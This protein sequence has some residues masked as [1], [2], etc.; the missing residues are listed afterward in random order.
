MNRLGYLGML[1]ATLL[2]VFACG[3]GGPETSGVGEMGPVSD[4]GRT[5]G[6]DSRFLES[7]PRRCT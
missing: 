7:G 1:L 6:D 4:R 3:S 5:E 2:L